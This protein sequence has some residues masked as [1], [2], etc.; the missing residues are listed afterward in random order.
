VGV[1]TPIRRQRL[2]I[3]SVG[4]R[5]LTGWSARAGSGHDA[6]Q[7]AHDE[8]P[9]TPCVPSSSHR[10]GARCGGWRAALPLP[11]LRLL[12]LLSGFGQPTY[13]LSAAEEA[14]AANMASYWTN[15]AKTGDPNGPALP[16][17]PQYQAGDE[18][19]LVLDQPLGE[20]DSYQRQQCEFWNTVPEL[21]L[22]HGRSFMP[23][24]V[25]HETGNAV[26]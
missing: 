2:L 22:P 12:D 3:P 21:F 14:L 11:R 5:L 24:E 9:V 10:D 6:D 23:K 20:V 19:S 17:W 13:E 4:R 18:R 15:F 7:A 1:E 26:R 16:E 8:N 25:P